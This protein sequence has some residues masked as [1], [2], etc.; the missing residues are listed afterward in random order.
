[1]MEEQGQKKELCAVR[2]ATGPAGRKSAS[3]RIGDRGG[4]LNRRFWALKTLTLY[5]L[6]R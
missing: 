6:C 3:E 4:S 2:T 5:R 1:M